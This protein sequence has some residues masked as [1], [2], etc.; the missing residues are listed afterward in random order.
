VVRA[1][2]KKTNT[3]VAIKFLDRPSVGLL[4][5]RVSIVALLYC[6]FD[7]H[8]NYMLYLQATT[9]YVEREIIN[10]YKLCHPHVIALYDVSA[11]G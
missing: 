8:V 6:R 2:D 5:K 3:D 1:R 11:Q 7:L 9:K 4:P 10:Q